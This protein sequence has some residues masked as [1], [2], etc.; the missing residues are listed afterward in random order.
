MVY[1]PCA[2]VTTFRVAAVPSYVNKIAA[3]GTAAPE[4]SVTVPT[5][6]PSDCANEHSGMT[7]SAISAN[8][9]WRAVL[10]KGRKIRVGTRKCPTWEHTIPSSIHDRCI[11]HLVERRSIQAKVLNRTF[12]TV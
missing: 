5:I 1:V 4:L 8:I 10:R 6:V 2:S 3:L 9:A 11:N 12:D 7:L